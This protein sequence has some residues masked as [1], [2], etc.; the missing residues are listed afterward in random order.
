MTY[1]TETADRTSSREQNR[2]TRGGGEVS[3]TVPS[4]E[5]E[6]A[7]DVGKEEGNFFTI[8]DE[9]T[10]EVIDSV[11]SETAR[12]ILTS[13]QERAQTP[14]EISDRLETSTQNV[15]YHLDKL[16]TAGLIEVGGIRYSEKGREMSVY[17]TTESPPVIVIGT[18]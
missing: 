4:T 7:E 11:A 6:K 17:E 13:V 3:T 2:E 16:E 18:G 12:K 9:E 1:T 14:A 10:E 8:D 15:R 5:R